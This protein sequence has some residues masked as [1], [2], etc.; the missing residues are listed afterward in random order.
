MKYTKNPS[1]AQARVATHHLRTT[2][3][4]NLSMCL[5]D[6]IDLQDISNDI[7]GILLKSYGFDSARH[8]R[9]SLK[10]AV[11]NRARAL[12]I[13]DLSKYRALLGSAGSGYE[14]ANLV[15]VFTVGET[16]FFR[17]PS[18]DDALV[19][20]VLPELI[21]RKSATRKLRIWSAGCATG[22]EPYTIAM[23]INEYFPELVNWDVRILATDVNNISL[24]QADQNNYSY[25]SL[26]N[27]P[28]EF[29]EKYFHLGDGSFHLHESCKRMVDFRHHNLM[30][31]KSLHNP[32]CDQ[33]DLIMCRNVLIYFDDDS[34]TYVV[35]KLL[36]QLEPDGYIF[37]GHT[38]M[39][40]NLSDD[41]QSTSYHDAFYCTRKQPVYEEG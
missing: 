35:N 4:A 3:T 39:M 22:E 12:G 40:Q 5:H 30:D 33:F 18:H 17:Y 36:K 24:F 16:N 28:K 27:V 15:D 41:L 25:R 11:K 10:S 1:C 37:F 31:T 19:N 14:L 7:Y 20:S 29:V 23:L 2:A 13:S 9:H 34:T 26:R 6:E 32:Q 21:R 8:S 38:E